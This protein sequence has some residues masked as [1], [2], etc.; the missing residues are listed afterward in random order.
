MPQPVYPDDTGENVIYQGLEFCI[1]GKVYSYDGTAPVIITGI[2]PKVYREHRSL[3][4]GCALQESNQMLTVSV[5]GIDERKPGTERI[6]LRL[7][8]LLIRH[9]ELLKKLLY[10]QAYE[11]RYGQYA[12][13]DVLDFTQDGFPDIFNGINDAYYPGAD[14]VHH[15]GKLGENVIYAACNVL[16]ISDNAFLN[17]R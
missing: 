2:V 10:P 9:E 11:L 14:G 17:P 1:P 16:E 7:E 8:S 4:S 5:Y 3:G 15:S 13:Y 6:Q 12:D